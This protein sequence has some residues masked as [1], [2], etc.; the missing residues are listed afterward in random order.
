MSFYLSQVISLF[1]IPAIFFGILWS[2]VEFRFYKIQFWS[3]FCAIF[4][5]A[6]CFIYLP[7]GQVHILIASGLYAAV[8]FLALLY[9]VMLRPSG[10]VVIAF[11][12]MV[13]LCASFMWAKIAKL[14]MLSA[15]NVINTDF[16][17]NGSALVAG[18]FLIVWCQVITTKIMSF[19]SSGLNRTM[20]CVLVLIALLPLSGEIML[21]A[22]KLQ[23]LG[24]TQG[25]LSYVSK[26][27]NFYWVYP[28]CALVFGLIGM[29]ALFLSQ[30]RPLRLA[31]A[32]FT[33]ALERRKNQAKINRFNG[34]LK[35]YGFI[36]ILI[37]SSLLYWDLVASQPLRRSPAT[38]IEL[39]ADQRVHIPVNE[40][41]VDGKLH[42]YEWVASD[43]KVVRFFIIDRYPG[44]KK[45]GVVFDA[46]MLCGDAGYTQV[47]DQVICLAC[48]VHIFI[49]SIG[50]PGGCNPIPIPKWTLHNN[51]ITIS[52]KMLESGLQYFS[53]VLEIT[54]TDPVNGEELS[55]KDADHT[56]QFGG[57]T[58]FFTS[59][60]T[61]EAFR[62]EPWK[63]ADSA[64]IN[65]DEEGE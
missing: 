25:L 5:G 8:L 32:G 45:F 51:E 13:L 36:I 11:Q 16:I 24:L 54:V 42:R 34:I 10:S 15:T 1:L 2:R 63:Y 46:C 65:N 14:S 23:I 62:A 29:T 47:G 27:T 26:V 28:Y 31:K 39:M 61:Y 12:A 3:S 19:L 21:S 35:Q 48:G 56:Y 30:V 6:A 43:G 9:G 59:E 22:I 40:T 20:T 58:Y 55:N 7:Y 37:L 57:K 4:V 17:L 44:E 53:E 60:A 64:A 49:P 18:F 38:R 41:L 52:K 33:S 50:K